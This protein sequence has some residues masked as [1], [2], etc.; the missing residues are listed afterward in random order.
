MTVCQSVWVTRAGVM[1]RVSAHVPVY[2]VYC[3]Y[4]D[5]EKR[6]SVASCGTWGGL[7][8]MPK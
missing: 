2:A 7:I 5:M 8:I 1:L 4:L 3:I 6:C